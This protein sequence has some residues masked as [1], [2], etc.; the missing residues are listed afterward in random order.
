MSLGYKKQKTMNLIYLENIL[1]HFL[2]HIFWYAFE[3]L[4]HYGNIMLFENYR[5][6]IPVKDVIEWQVIVVGHDNC[7]KTH[8][9]LLG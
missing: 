5:E 8:E 3:N 9:L 2:E 4:P 7:R 6:C 1:T